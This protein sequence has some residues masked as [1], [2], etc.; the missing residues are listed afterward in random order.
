[1]KVSI[2]KQKF[3]QVVRAVAP[4]SKLLRTWQL[5]GGI[6]VDMIA[7]EFETPNG[8]TRRMIVR[9]HRDGHGKQSLHKAESEFRLLK[10]IHPLGLSTPKPYHLDKSGK[11][12][13]TPYL[14]IEYIEG[15]MEF[16]PSNLEDHIH[17]LATQLAEIH[18]VDYSNFNLSFLPQNVNGCAEMGRKRPTTMNTSLDEA[19]IRDALASIWPLPEGNAT[20]LLHG[21]FW[22]G[23]TLWRDGQLVAVID[24]EDAKLGDPLTDFAKSRSEIGWIFGID[25]MHAFTHYYKSMMTINYTNLPYWDLCA[26]LRFIRWTGGNLAE[27]AA[28]FA[29]FGRTDIS[30][31]TIRDHY[32][33]FIRQAF[34]ALEVHIAARHS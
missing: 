11:I 32:R 21:D 9:L 1:M 7:L 13:S 12:F 4:Q 31:E 23:N 14:I 28:Y 24:W 26:A 8:Q 22:P 15:K 6:S 10:Q 27:V 18:S 3:E 2:E 30:A 20:A 29:P 5:T 34:E 25:A 16:S 17:Q 19:R 33:Y